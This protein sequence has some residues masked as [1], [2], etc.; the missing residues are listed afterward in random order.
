MVK[1]LIS[2]A[3]N[4]SVTVEFYSNHLEILGN[5]TEKVKENYDEVLYYIARKDFAILVKTEK[6]R[7]YIQMQR[8][9]ELDEFLTGKIERRTKPRPFWK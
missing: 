1:N 9:L 6:E 8:N 4:N 7:V 3:K 2:N 5:S